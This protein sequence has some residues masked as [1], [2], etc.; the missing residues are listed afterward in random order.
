[1]TKNESQVQKIYIQLVTDV[2]KKSNKFVQVLTPKKEYI[3]Y[4]W[5]RKERSISRIECSSEQREE[6]KVKMDHY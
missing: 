5:D 2:W 4:S 6:A 3:K 1:M